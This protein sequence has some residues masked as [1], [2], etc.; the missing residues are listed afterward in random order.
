[1]TEEEVDSLVESY[2]LLV[3]EY[4]AFISRA[5]VTKSDRKRLLFV[6]D[7]E[8]AYRSAQVIKAE[9]LSM[10]IKVRRSM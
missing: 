8:K 10:G 3:A 1:M 7:A 2:V 6:T 4:E 5:K 9:L